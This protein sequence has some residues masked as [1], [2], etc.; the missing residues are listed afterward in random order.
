[1]HRIQR[2]L[3]GGDVRLRSRNPPRPLEDFPKQE[4]GE[5]DRY[6]HIGRDE[7]VQIKTLGR[8]GE[9]V[10]TI[11][12]RDEGEEDEAEPCRVWLESRLEDEG[13]AVDTL[14]FECGVELD[15]GDGDGH[16]GEKIGNRGQV[17]EPGEDGGGAGRAGHVSQEGDG[18][19]DEDAVVWDTPGDR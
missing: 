16:P 14:R 12:Q 4:Q 17:L 2:R 1:M 13:V 9:D 19:G 18:G 3:A 7:V 11:E 8:A 6:A 15:V 5:I 10:E